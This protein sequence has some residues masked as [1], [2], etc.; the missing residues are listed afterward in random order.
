MLKSR[1]EMSEKAQKDEI[2]PVLKDMKRSIAMLTS[3]Q[4]TIVKQVHQERRRLHSNK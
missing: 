1:L 4:N 2:V 3:N